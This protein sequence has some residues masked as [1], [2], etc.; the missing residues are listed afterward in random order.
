ME[1]KNI[2]IGLY[3]EFPLSNGIFTEYHFDKTYF[4]KA[5]YGE[6]PKYYMT[7]LGNILN[8][9]SWWNTTY[10][11][12]LVEL[13][14]DMNGLELGLGTTTFLGK[15]N[16]IANAGVTLYTL[17]YNNLSNDTFNAIF[18]TSLEN[19][20]ELKVKGR[21]VALHFNLAKNIKLTTIGKYNLNK[22][23]LHLF[24]L[25]QHKF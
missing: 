17:N 25:W 19:G 1:K 21:L 11:N 10:S 5:R 14:T 8:N 7:A 18:G 15:E 2:H 20:R 9:F 4:F 16:T 23:K 22:F 24:I 13:C 3:S 12:L 6:S